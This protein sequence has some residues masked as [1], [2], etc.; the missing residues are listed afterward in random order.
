MAFIG[1][2]T[3]VM[4]TNRGQ[5]QEGPEHSVTL[6]PFCID[7]SE[8]TVAQYQQCV[9]ARACSRATL[10]G[11]VTVSSTGDCN[12]ERPGRALHPVNCVSW[13]QAEAFCAWAGGRLP[14]EAEWEM[15][16]RDEGTLPDGVQRRP[17]SIAGAN[18]CGDEC[19]TQFTTLQ[20]FPGHHDAFAS[21]APVGS[22][23][24]GSTSRLVHDMLGNV[25]EW[26]ADGYARYSAQAASNPIGDPASSKRAVRGGG[27][28]DDDPERVTIT[29]REGIVP[30]YVSPNLGFRCASRR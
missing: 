20:R 6:S 4:G 21:T 17:A 25:F 27:W 11:A 7:R 18:V 8:V 13:H 28:R 1:G 5:P 16:A 15:T 2:G 23:P 24:A 9:E 29:Y 26:V 22:M 10:E 30:A 19:V 12:S 14:T 3:F